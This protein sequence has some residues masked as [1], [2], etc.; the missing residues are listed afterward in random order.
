LSQTKRTEEQQLAES[1]SRPWLVAA[2]IAM[3]RTVLIFLAVGAATSA[4]LLYLAAANDVCL[5]R[6]K[7]P[8][9]HF[10]SAV[11]ISREGRR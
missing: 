6:R 5:F 7:M 8:R 2:A 4:V 1:K 9:Q 3:A 10:Y 11:A